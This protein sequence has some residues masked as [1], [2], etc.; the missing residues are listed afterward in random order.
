MT[1]FKKEEERNEMT[2]VIKQ[3][4]TTKIIILRFSCR[5]QYWTLDLTE[6]TED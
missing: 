6:K 4:A 1:S 3:N 2:N 5:V